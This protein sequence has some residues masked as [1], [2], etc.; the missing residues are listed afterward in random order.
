M[1]T[2]KDNAMWQMQGVEKSGGGR[3]P[4]EA[5][6]APRELGSS[7]AP[8]T[9]CSYLM[10]GMTS[11]CPLLRPGQASFLREASPDH[12]FSCSHFLGNPCSPRGT[13]HLPSLFFCFW[14]KRPIS[15][16]RLCSIQGMVLVLQSSEIPVPRW[17]R[18]ILGHTYFYTSVWGF[19]VCSTWAALLRKS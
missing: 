6:L 15:A 8:P 16:V 10:P 9:L 2:D 11:P 13:E 4:E 17:P 1:Q 19:F 18:T 12:D 3:N 14:Y 5:P 7:R